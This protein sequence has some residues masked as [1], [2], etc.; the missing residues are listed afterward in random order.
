MNLAYLKSPPG[1]ETIA[2]S[3]AF[4]AQVDRVWRAWTVPEQ[5]IRWFGPPDGVQGYE[6]DVRVGGRWRVAYVADDLPNA[7]EGE[8]VVVE[9]N[10][11]LTFTWRH[12]REL[13]DGE[14]AT[15]PVS[16]VSVVFREIEGA[17][18]IS[19]THAGIQAEGSRTSISNGW[20][21][22]FAGLGRLLAG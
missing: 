7:I 5:L 20:D 12:V 4:K 21:A 1:A 15:S 2:V 9:E 18:E 13:P 8:Y 17:T 3:G 14:T 6:A 19:L 10:A 16:T 11:R 22:C